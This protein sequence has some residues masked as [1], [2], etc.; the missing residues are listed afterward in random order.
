MKNKKEKEKKNKQSFFNH[1][2]NG[3]IKKSQTEP[4]GN[5]I[6]I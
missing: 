4:I 3:R 2:T 6:L 5:K 1:F